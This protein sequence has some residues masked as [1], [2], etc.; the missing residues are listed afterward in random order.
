[1]IDGE[2]VQR[3]VGVGVYGRGGGADQAITEVPLVAHRSGAHVD[4]R[5]GERGAAT[6]GSQEG[7]GHR[8]EYL[9]LHGG[10]AGAPM[11]R[12]GGEA[13]RIRRW[14]R[15]AI[16]EPGVRVHTVTDRGALPIAIGPCELVSTGGGVD[17]FHSERV[18]A[19]G[20]S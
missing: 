6:V 1:G 4:E 15:P 12:G 8:R 18:T 11:H 14:S 10:R 13:D 20:R 9:H 3:W 5:H 19:G 17:Q 2:V 16:V 7:R